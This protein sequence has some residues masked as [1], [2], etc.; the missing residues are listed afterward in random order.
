MSSTPPLCLSAV[1]FFSS[2]KMGPDSQG[3]L[4]RIRNI[5]KHDALLAHEGRLLLEHA[6][7]LK[8]EDFFKACFEEEALASL[9]MSK[10]NN[11]T[12]NRPEIAAS[13]SRVTRQT[14]ASHLPQPADTREKEGI[15]EA[16]VRVFKELPKEYSHERDM[17]GPI[18]SLT[19]LRGS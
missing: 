3:N 16:F 8:P 19:F 11:S 5:A 18:V 9:E 2:H 15:P 10:G 12:I 1:G 14:K 17:Y 13:N 7:V 6:T 4:T